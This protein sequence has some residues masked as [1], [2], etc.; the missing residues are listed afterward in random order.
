MAKISNASALRYPPNSALLLSQSR[1]SG[2]DTP[3]PL[4]NAFDT[5]NSHIP[6]LCTILRSRSFHNLGS[7]VSFCY[8]TVDGLIY[9]HGLPLHTLACI[10]SHHISLIVALQELMCVS[11]SYEI[12]CSD[13][14]SI[15]TT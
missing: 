15:L 9:S 8:L 13:G 6:V 10:V 4:L 2:R 11:D 7:S 1:K 12:Y 5:A 3:K 14:R